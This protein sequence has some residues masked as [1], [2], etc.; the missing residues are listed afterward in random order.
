MHC[1]WQTRPKFDAVIHPVW[2]SIHFIL[3]PCPL[4]LSPISTLWQ[5][6]ITYWDLRVQHMLR[7]SS[8]ACGNWRWWLGRLGSSQG[9]NCSSHS[10]IKPNDA[11]S[12]LNFWICSVLVVR[13][14]V[15]WG[16]YKSAFGF[17][18]VCTRVDSCALN[19]FTGISDATTG[20]ISHFAGLFLCWSREIHETVQFRPQQM[21]S[22][23]L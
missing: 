20:P 16:S 4:V 14:W 10:V 15:G 2:Q 22:S 13:K 3:S 9:V 7:S 1:D 17:S 21:K 12:S 19:F 23:I 8:F 5:S 6:V 18:F 11:R